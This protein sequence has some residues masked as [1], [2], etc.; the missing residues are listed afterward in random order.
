MPRALRDLAV[1]RVAAIGCQLGVDGRGWRGLDLDG[2][3]VAVEDEIGFRIHLR[4]AT[5]VA[6]RLEPKASLGVDHEWQ[7]GE[8][9]AHVLRTG[10]RVDE[11]PG[12]AVED[13]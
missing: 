2:I 7:V 10:R 3:A 13:A 5:R 9:G 4:D 12:V 11:R 6:A 1:E 8:G